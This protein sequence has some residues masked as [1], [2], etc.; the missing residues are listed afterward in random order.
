MGHTKQNSNRAANF[1]VE[2]HYHTTKI[3]SV[4]SQMK[5]ADG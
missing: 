2:P 5:Y 3:Q 4:V 1:S